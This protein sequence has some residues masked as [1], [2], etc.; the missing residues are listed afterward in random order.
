MRK[1][2]I[3]TLQDNG[4]TLRFKVRQMPATEQEKFIFKVLLLLCGKELGDVD[5]IALRKDP[6]KYIKPSMI[7][8]AMQNLEY[9]KIETLINML[10]SCCYRI[11]GNMEEQC[12]P[13]TVNGYVESFWTLLSLKKAALEVSFDFFEEDGNSQATTSKATI[14]IGKSSQT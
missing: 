4:N 8:S 7:F 5:V 6:M 2:K 11:N 12:T 9:E 1:E 10:L 3:I 14:E 13:E